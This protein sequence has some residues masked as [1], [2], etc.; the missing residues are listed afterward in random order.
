MSK[1]IGM[2]ITQL[3]IQYEDS[4]II[5]YNDHLG[6][7]SPQPGEHLP[8]VIISPSMRLYNHLHNTLH[9]VLLFKGLKPGKNNLTKIAELQQWLNTNF[10]E[11]TKTHIITKEKLELDNIILDSNNIIHQRYQVK[12]PAIY[13]IRPDNYI[14]YCSKELDSIAL[15]QFLRRYLK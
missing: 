6:A 8:D 1:K 2:Q 9:N 15:E 4:P 10:P 5:D 11:L 13:I 14:A 12:T 3:S 7:K